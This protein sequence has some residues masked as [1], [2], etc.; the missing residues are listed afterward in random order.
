MSVLSIVY[1]A[2]KR[3]GWPAMPDV[4]RLN[5]RPPLVER[6][7]FAPWYEAYIVFGSVGSMAV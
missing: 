1:G 5:E 7:M 3:N 4:M 2:M 6:N